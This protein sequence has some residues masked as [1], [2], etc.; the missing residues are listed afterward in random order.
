MSLPP[1]E[2]FQKIPRYYRDIVI[3]EKIDGTNGQILIPEGGATFLTTGGQL[4]PFLVGSR[5]RW[6]FPES[7]NHGFAKWAYL[8]AMDILQL[9]PGHHFGEWWGAGIQR[10]YGQAIKRF[11]LFNTGRW[12]DKTLPKG[13]ELVPILYHGPHKESAITDTIDGLRAYGSIAASNYMQPEGIVIFHP[14]SGKLFKVTLEGDEKPKGK[15]DAPT[16]SVD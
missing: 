3:T 1:F 12:L 8:N 13:I 14:A 15:D 11:S 2:S 10:G 16:I 9:G 5:N 7:D 6:I 4:L